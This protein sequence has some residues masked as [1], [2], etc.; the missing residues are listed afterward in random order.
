MKKLK[1]ILPILLGIYVLLCTIL[2]FGQEKLLFRN[3][4]LPETHVFNFNIPFEEIDI[5]TTDNILI[6]SL[7]FKAD[8]SKGVVLF[9]HGNGGTIDMWG[10]GAALYTQ[11][12]YNVLYIDYRG[13]GKT[14]G[15]IYSE[16]QFVQDAQAAYDYLKEM[17]KEENIIVSG[18]SMGTGLATQIAAKNNPKHLILNAPYSSLRKVATEKFPIFPGFIVKYPLITKKHIKEVKCPITIFHGTKDVVIPYHHAQELI[19]SNP[20]A[21]LHT[22]DGY[23][24]YLRNSPVYNSETGK[25]LQQ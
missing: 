16:E 12:N 7:L 25:I 19:A 15:N 8:S 1:F 18:T 13:Y 22:L 5:K 3:D 6:N 20:K 11:N 24:H 2:Y 17:Y 9:L 10:R 14:E 4:M 21:I 23:G